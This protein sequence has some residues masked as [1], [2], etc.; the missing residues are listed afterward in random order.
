MKEKKLGGSHQRR[1]S[2]VVLIAICTL[3][4]GV[5]CKLMAQEMA[6]NHETANSTKARTSLHQEVVFKSSPQRIYEV[7]VS[8]KEF[9]AFSGA[10]A[11]INPSAGGE[12]SMFGGR[13]AG[14]TVELVPNRRIVQ[15]W[16]PVEDFPEGVYSLVKIELEPSGSGT[17]LILDQTGF[18]E[19]R[20]DHL[21]A[22]WHSHYWDP[23]KKYL[24]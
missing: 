15:A 23:L 19:G 1:V 7:L 21:D 2:R 6:T 8:S 22:G 17:K 4:A 20:F 24:E 11:Q 10:P 5:A 3:S 18:P 12:F 16:R 13:I 9:T 14:R